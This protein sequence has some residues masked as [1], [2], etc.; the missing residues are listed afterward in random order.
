MIIGSIPVPKKLE[1]PDRILTA[2]RGPEIDTSSHKVPMGADEWLAC[3]YA[4]PH[5]DLHVSRDSIYLTLA[6]KSSHSVGDTKAD[7]PLIAVP[8]GTLFIVD[9]T[10]FHWLFAEDAWQSTR[11]KPFIAIQWCIKR[12]HAAKRI[13][14]ILAKTGGTWAP[15]LERRYAKQLKRNALG[16]QIKMGDP[17]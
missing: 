17:I 7:Q 16:Q 11:T 2:S 3:A 12:R 6:M 14:E 13:P 10:L 5:D 15:Q 1:I 8:K 9:P 4:T